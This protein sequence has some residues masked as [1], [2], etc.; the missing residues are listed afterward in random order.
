MVYA[1]VSATDAL[2]IT[3]LI[4]TFSKF[5]WCLTNLKTFPWLDDITQNSQLD[6]VMQHDA[7]TVKRGQ[8]IFV[9]VE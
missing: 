6:A 5:L 7:L 8:S 4:T 9:P 3:K 1:D 2:P